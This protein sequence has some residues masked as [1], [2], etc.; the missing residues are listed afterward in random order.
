MKRQI[1][2]A[3]VKETTKEETSELFKESVSITTAMTSEDLT[4]GRKQYASQE[5][6][7]DE[8]INETDNREIPRRT[9][10]RHIE[11]M[12]KYHRKTQA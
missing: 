7:D 10:S 1:A 6:W 5:V 2:A 11:K 12:K 9:A 4:E 8:S 3:A